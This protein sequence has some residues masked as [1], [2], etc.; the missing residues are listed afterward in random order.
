MSAPTSAAD[1]PAPADSLRT[2]VRQAVIWRSG[3]QIFS[4]LGSGPI[5]SLALEAI[6]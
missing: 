5:K 4:Q 3:T 2:R 6:G 1:S